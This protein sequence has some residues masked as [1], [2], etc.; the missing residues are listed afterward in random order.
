MG[1]GTVGW[2]STMLATSPPW[3]PRDP[4]AADAR[5]A[6][7]EVRSLADNSSLGVTLW[8]RV[9]APRSEPPPP[10]ADQRI[11]DGVRG[12]PRS[13]TLK[14]GW[15]NEG[16]R[17]QRAEAMFSP[18]RRSCDQLRRVEQLPTRDSDLMGLAW[19]L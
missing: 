12:T 5:A 6:E 7:A 14:E 2:Y 17:Q 13:V 4:D 11:G 19:L 16:I 8:V 9:T 10:S 15:L 3:T 18:S 1:V